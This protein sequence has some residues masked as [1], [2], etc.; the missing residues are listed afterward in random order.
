MADGSLRITFEFDPHMAREAFALFGARGTPCAV[1]ALT[2]QAAIASA[3]QEMIDADPPVEQPD[4]V[5]GLALLAVMWC[6]DQDFWD[7]VN[8]EFGEDISREEECADWLKEFLDI[9]S[10]KE[11]M[12][13]VEA[14]AA[15]HQQVRGP[16]ML[17]MQEKQ[18]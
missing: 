18:D 14:Q 2:A 6:K 9:E 16:Y 12:T 17:W 8:A 11:L 4:K 3:Q 15:F 13:S 10:R 7:F 5:T 1:A